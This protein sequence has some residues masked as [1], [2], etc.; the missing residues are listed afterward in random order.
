MAITSSRWRAASAFIAAG[1]AV[2]AVLA[3]AVPAGA[4]TGTAEISPEQAGYTATGAQFKF[5]NASV[6]LRQPGQYSSEVASFGHSVQLWSSGLVITLGVTASTSG[7]GYTTYAAIYDRSTHRVIASNPDGQTCDRY[8]FCTPGPA[9]LDPGLPVAMVI[10]YAP[11]SGHLLMEEFYSDSEDNE[12]NFVSDYTA[13]GQSFTQARVGIDFGSTPWDG[14]YSHTPPAQYTKAAAY[15]GASLITYS[16]HQSSLWSWWLHHKL[17]A[18]TERQSGSDWVA[19]PADLTNGGA[20]F[21]TWFVPQS[22]QGQTQPV[23]P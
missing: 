8:G 3:S 2:A 4:S 16:G 1:A 10:S 13:A 23:L 14:S 22:S 6:F 20:N 7:G 18:N 11:A 19:I 21:Q 15:T 5:I 12:T 17:L 9:T